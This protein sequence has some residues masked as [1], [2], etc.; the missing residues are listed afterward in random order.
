MRILVES[1]SMFCVNGCLVFRLPVWL[2]V[3]LAYLNC[4]VLISSQILSGFL[5]LIMLYH[6]L[7]FVL[8]LNTLLSINYY[9]Q[10]LESCS[11][12]EELTIDK[13]VLESI[14]GVEHLNQLKWLSVSSNHLSSFPPLHTLTQLTYLNIS[15]NYVSSLMHLKVTYRLKV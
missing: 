14:T 8:I 1:M 6:L 11:K 5:C 13:N 7:R 4:L 12:L 3:A 15:D 10:G 2:C 9:T